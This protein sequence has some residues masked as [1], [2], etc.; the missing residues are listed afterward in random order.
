MADALPFDGSE[1]FLRVRYIKVGQAPTRDDG[2]THN[3]TDPHIIISRVRCGAYTTR[4]GG[5]MVQ[6]AAGEA[7][8]APPHTPLAI[9]HHIDPHL[10]RM[11]RSWI[12][13]SVAANE[14]LDIADLIELP[15]HLDA[16]A[17]APFGEIMDELLGTSVQDLAAHARRRELAYRTLRLLAA[18]SRPRPGAAELLSRRSVL[19]T[20]IAHLH[21]RLAE[22]HDVSELARVAGVSSATLHRHFLAHTR[23][24]PLR[25]LKGLRLDA[26][27]RLLAEGDL[28]LSD[29][30][31][32]VGFANP[33]HFSREFT[34]RFHASPA[35]WRALARDGQRRPS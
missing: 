8:V 2:W 17:T 26:S 7:Y 35:A 14:V 5:H 9:T 11:E 23:C 25:Y 32:R 31:A 1:D 15:I 18:R 10:G 30:A 27:C 28:P 19:G 6:V 4:W 21:Q 3:K 13:H 16:Q 20:V 33:F 34:R 22:P 12:H 29:V 24:T